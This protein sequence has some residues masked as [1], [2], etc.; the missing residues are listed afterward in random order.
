MEPMDITRYTGVNIPDVLKTENEKQ[1][2]RWCMEYMH[3]NFGDN[4]EYEHML[5]QVLLCDETRDYLYGNPPAPVPYVRGMRPVLDRVV[6]EVTAGC[7]TD[8]EKVMAILRYV[9]DLYQEFDG[10]D[11]FFGGTEEELIKK[12]EWFCERV[13]R[14]QVALCEVAGFPGRIVFHIAA[15][16]LTSEIYFD[17]KWAYMDP[18]CG[19]YYLWEDGS[20]MSVD[21]IIHHR[22]RIYQQP[23]EVYDFHSPYWSVE[24]RCHRNY[25]FCMSPLEINCFTAYSL[26]D[27]DTYHFGWTRHDDSARKADPAHQKYIEYGAMTLIR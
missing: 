26:T 1:T 10:E 16:H 21:E 2:Y 9:R 22:E 4:V 20:F 19:I 23:Q 15:G 3:Q 12:H 18:R 24:Y 11:M 14:L 25:H 13:A 17:G 7:R 5:R 8:R 6:D 27:A